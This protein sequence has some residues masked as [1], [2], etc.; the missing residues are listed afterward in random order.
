MCDQE[1]DHIFHQV[2]PQVLI[3]LAAQTSVNQSMT[4]P[5]DEATGASLVKVPLWGTEQPREHLPVRPTAGP[6]AG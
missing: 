1:I 4:S 2:K 5:Y 3:H 6:D